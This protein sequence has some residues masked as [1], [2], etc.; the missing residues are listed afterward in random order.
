MLEKTLEK[1]T[2]ITGIGKSDVARPSL[3]SPLRQ[4]VDACLQA[5]TDAGLTRDDIDGISTYPGMLPDTSGLGPVGV[6]EVRLA[7]GLKLSWYSGAKETSGQLGAVFNAVAAVAAGLANHVLVF[8]T[9]NEATVRKATKGATAIGGGAPRVGGIHQWTTPFQAISAAMWFGLYAQR[10]FH[11]YGTTS[12]H[13]GEIVLNARRNAMRNPDAIYR[14]P[15]TMEQYLASRYVST[16]LRLFDC[17][18]PVDSA[19]AI[20]VSRIEAAKDLKNSVIR[21]EAIGS[22]IHASD[23]W[24]RPQDLTQCASKDAADM[25]WRRTSLKPS[26][27]DVAQLYDGFSIHTLLWLEALGFCGRGEGGPFVEGGHRIAIDGELPLNTSG[28]QL[29]AGRLHGLGHL[30][31]ACVQ[32]WGRGGER[33]V[34]G[35]PQVSVATAGLGGAFSGCMLIVRE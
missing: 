23:T 32:L 2:A 13:L 11:E 15:L 4:T 22:A 26:D 10:H 33:Q 25:M 8:R 30:H 20:I 29:S 19:V 5:I 7:L 21:I 14:D 6:H 34:P 28:G 12:R 9:I 27:V 18:V 3:K 1:T 31:E 17:D 16:P 24:L 35:N